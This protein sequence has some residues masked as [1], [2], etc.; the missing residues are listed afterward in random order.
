MKKSITESQL[1]E[2]VYRNYHG[3]TLTSIAKDFGIGQSTLSQLKSRRAADW[4]RIQHQIV[5]TEIVRLVFGNGC[6]PIPP[7]SPSAAS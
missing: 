4:E 6:D 1:T 2:A 7:N 3:E 5:A